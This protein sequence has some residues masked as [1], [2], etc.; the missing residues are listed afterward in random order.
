MRREAYQLQ[1]VAEDLDYLRETWKDGASD[2]DL[3][4][5]SALLRRLLVDGG[6]GVLVV[7]WHEIGFEGQPTV[8]A[9]RLSSN[10]LTLANK[11]ILA[12]AGGATV[13]GVDMAG[14]LRFREP[15][16]DNF[17]PNGTPQ[18]LSDYVSEPCLIIH[19]QTIDRR[20]LVKYFAHHLGGVHMSRKAQKADE[21]VV[22]CFRQI[23]DLPI[24][25]NLLGKDLLHFELLAIGQSIGRS[26]DSIKLASAIRAL[27]A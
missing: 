5:G 2:S 22:R 13:N 27:L 14:Y 16:D 3:R 17:S 9:P 25:A 4:R 15:F 7:V 24:Q 6:N 10:S 19:G 21:H 23:E 1:S 12:T 18:R 20:E 8:V 11:V 26:E